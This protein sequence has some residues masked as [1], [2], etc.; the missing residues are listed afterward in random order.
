MT[1]QD[2]VQVSPPPSRLWSP[3][4]AVGVIGVA[5]FVLTLV[6]DAKYFPELPITVNATIAGFEAEAW[7]AAGIFLEVW[8]HYFQRVGD[9]GSESPPN[10]LAVAT[11]PSPEQPTRPAD[12]EPAAHD[13]AAG[14]R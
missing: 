1:P 9:H 5:A 4:T 8:L 14:P 10:R 12:V 6:L 13:G 3:A 7:V 2:L 11:A